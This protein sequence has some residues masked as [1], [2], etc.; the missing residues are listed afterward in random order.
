MLCVLA[1]LLIGFT[2][3]YSAGSITNINSGVS[4]IKALSDQVLYAAIGIVCAVVIYFFVKPDFWRGRGV[5]L[6][7]G[8]AMLLIIA[9]TVFGTENYGATR[10]IRIGPVSVQ[11]SEFVKI[12]LVIVAARLFADYRDGALDFKSFMLGA[13]LLVVVPLGFMYLTQSDLGTTMICA[14]A[15]L[16]VMWYGEVPIRTFALIL[17]LIFVVG[18]IAIFGVGYRANR[19][20][21]LDP[22]QDQYGTG[23]NIIHSY[24]AIADGGI[25]GV[26]LGNGHE[27]YQY[28]FASD[29]DFVFAVVCEELGMVGA[30][31]VIGLFLL[32]AY[33][34]SLIARAAR[35]DF[36]TMLAGGLSVALAFQAFLNMGC[37]IGV[38][39]TTGK[40]LPFISSGGS[41]VIASLMMVGLILSVSREAGSPSV[42]DRRRAGLRVVRAAGPERDAVRVG[43]DSPA[44]ASGRVPEGR[45]RTSRRSSERRTP[46]RSSSRRR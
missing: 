17:A 42:Y 36:S 31:L 13:F 2:M 9:T 38:F 10:W 26:G 41:S 3:V 5:W 39:P 27:K 1:L 29:S 18:V 32:V 12:A 8:V 19:F 4:A 30:L 7:W 37:A 43:A 21:Y 11:G 16:A 25:F 45:E 33:T 28:L 24:Y 22:W 46:S 14:V 20:A 35:D 6:A 34:G 23:Y 44:R 15:L 40:P